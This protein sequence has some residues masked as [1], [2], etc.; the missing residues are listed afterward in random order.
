MSVGKSY[1]LG[2]VMHK[3][4]P[5][6]L[7]PSSP[8]EYTPVDTSPPSGPRTSRSSAPS[9]GLLAAMVAGAP[10]EA[11]DCGKLLTPMLV[12]GWAYSLL[13][14]MTLSMDEKFRDT[15]SMEALH[16]LS[17]FLMLR[18]LRDPVTRGPA[19]T[20]MSTTVLQGTNTTFAHGLA[21]C[22]TE[23]V[24]EALQDKALAGKGSEIGIEEGDCPKSPDVATKAKDLQPGWH[25][26]RDSILLSRVT[27]NHGRT[28]LHYAMIGENDTM[29]GSLLNWGH[30]MC[31][32][33][34]PVCERGA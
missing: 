33:T 21:H 34:D 30:D 22:A 28:L 19:I 12:Q 10:S 4:K 18:V 27:D 23:E 15:I 31:V 17:N 9:A 26:V 14:L 8:V 13:S 2:H 32:G 6:R 7:S 25:L 24:I 16:A 29:C 3:P 20:A 1:S 5:H 11:E